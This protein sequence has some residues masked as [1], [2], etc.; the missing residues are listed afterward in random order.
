LQMV[1]LLKFKE[2]VEGNEWSGEIQ[3]RKYI[4]AIQSYFKASG[5]ELVFYGAMEMTIIGPENEK[6]WDK[7]IIV[8][9]PS[10]AH[11]MKMATAEN[12]PHH[13]RI[14]ALEDS[15]LYFCSLAK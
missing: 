2:K 10:K 11:F 15:R 12:Y 5:A 14:M 1:N 7:I 13:L 4:E 8:R 9:Y 6:E 3:Y